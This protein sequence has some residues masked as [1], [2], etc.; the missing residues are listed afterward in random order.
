MTKHAHI[1]QAMR[2]PAV[3]ILWAVSFKHSSFTWQTGGGDDRSIYLPV[4]LSSD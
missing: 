1:I 4:L 2:L 3:S